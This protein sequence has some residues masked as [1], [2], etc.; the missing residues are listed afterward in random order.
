MNDINEARKIIERIKERR[1]GEISAIKENL[2]Q[3]AA[4]LARV[5]SQIEDAKRAGDPGLYVPLKEQRDNIT[6]RRPCGEDKQRNRREPVPAVCV[7]EEGIG[8]SHTCYR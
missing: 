3:E 4:D 5:D 7:G 2:E 6:A 1:G 8:V